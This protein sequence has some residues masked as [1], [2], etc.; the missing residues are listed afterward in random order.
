MSDSCL[1]SMPFCRASRYLVNGSAVYSVTG[2]PHCSAYDNIR[3]I[4]LCKL[5]DKSIICGFWMTSSPASGPD[6][7]GLPGLPDCFPSR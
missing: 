6:A 5:N 1:L 2:S 7:S 4:V 3:Y